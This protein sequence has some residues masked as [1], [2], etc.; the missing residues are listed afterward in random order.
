MEEIPWKA[1][2]QECDCKDAVR[3]KE[4]RQ[5]LTHLPVQ[6]PLSPHFPSFSILFSQ[7]VTIL[8][9]NVCPR[10]ECALWRYSGER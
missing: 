6:A 4:I 7:I 5:P 1:G 2:A 3:L 9:G 10:A 8:A